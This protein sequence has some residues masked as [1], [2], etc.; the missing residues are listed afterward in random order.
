M[1]MLS[2]TVV[3]DIMKHT[4]LLPT[5]AAEHAPYLGHDAYATIFDHD[6][7]LGYVLRHDVHALPCVG[8]LNDE[9]RRPIVFTQAK[10]GFNHGW[11]V[12]AEAPPGALFSQA[13]V[14]LLHGSHRAPYSHCIQRALLSLTIAALSVLLLHMAGRHRRR[15]R[16]ERR[17]GLL[18]CTLAH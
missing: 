10:L 14:A 2:L 3:H 8:L 16:L 12:Q 5:V 13:K 11:L 4:V 18:L 1:A 6:I 7:A 17:H 9:Q 15:R